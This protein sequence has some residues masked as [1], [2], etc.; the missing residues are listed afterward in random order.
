MTAPA[1][2]NSALAT[3]EL[4]D[5]VEERIVEL[6]GARQAVGETLPEFPVR[7]LF[8][9]G[10][11]C[12]EI[13]MPAGSVLTSRI[14]KTEHPFIVSKGHCWVFT[15]NGWVEIRAPHFGITKAGTRR[16]LA[17]MSETVWTTCHVTDLTDPAEIDREILEDYENPLL[18]KESA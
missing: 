17:I 8:T 5:R 3:K 11:Y 12:R 14:H 10:L 4:I 2:V 18:A 13:T 1:F 9:P 6:G 15:E 7:H 16:V